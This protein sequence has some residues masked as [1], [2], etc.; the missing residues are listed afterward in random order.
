MFMLLLNFSYHPPPPAASPTLLWYLMTLIH[1]SLSSSLVARSLSSLSLNLP[2][3]LLKV[4]MAKRNNP[5][6]LSVSTA[7]TWHLDRSIW[8]PFIGS[9]L[10]LKSLSLFQYPILFPVMTKYLMFQFLRPRK[11]FP[12]PFFFKYPDLCME[13]LDELTSGCEVHCWE[14]SIFSFEGRR[15]L[16][17]MIISS[18]SAGGGG[19]VG[20]FACSLASSLAS[21]SSRSYFP[22][23]G[24]GS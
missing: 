16:L 2:S 22:S 20:D 23:A 15:G 9:W 17:T 24:G 4:F 1:P 10:D 8:L 19:G 18:S 6:Y 7:S 12:E 5:A 21:S 13:L 14:C 3:S 11:L